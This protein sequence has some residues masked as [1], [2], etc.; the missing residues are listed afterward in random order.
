MMHKQ[1]GQWL[2]NDTDASLT[3]K[4]IALYSD[5]IKHRTPSVEGQLLTRHIN[6]TLWNRLH[7]REEK[8]F[9]QLPVSVTLVSEADRLEE[10]SKL[11][12]LEKSKRDCHPRKEA[13]T[14]LNLLKTRQLQKLQKTVTQMESGQADDI[15]NSFHLEQRWL[16]QP[17]HQGTSPFGHEKQGRDDAD[18]PRQS[19][20]TALQGAWAPEHATDEG[21]NTSKQTELNANDNSNQSK[22]A[23]GAFCGLRLAPDSVADRGPLTEQRCNL[24]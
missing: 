18:N 15:D 10:E 24:E 5:L 6:E 17:C 12:R 16:Q 9:D 3:V 20:G 7:H 19:A 22:T 21:E 23:E 14:H 13:P 8:V 1:R 4:A 11:E 2:P